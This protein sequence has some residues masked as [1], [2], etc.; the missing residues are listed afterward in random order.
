MKTKHLELKRKALVQ[1]R[2]DLIGHFGETVAFDGSGEN[3]LRAAFRRLRAI[4]SRQN[5]G[6][7]MTVDHFGRKTFGLELF[8]ISLHIVLIHRGL[9]LAERVDVR[10]YSQIVELVVAGEFRRFP[11]LSF[12]HFS[13]AEQD[14]NARIALI[15]ARPDC[16]SRANG[17]S[18]AQ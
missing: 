4:E 1:K 12:G 8:A 7:I 11:D 6:H 9:A 10:D 3:R 13:I 15:H 14:V 5:C 18:L 16:E 17:K 2:E